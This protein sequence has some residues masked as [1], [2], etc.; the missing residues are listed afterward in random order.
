MLSVR[1]VAYT[2][3]LMHAKS[4]DKHH[5]DIYDDSRTV[6]TTTLVRP[7]LLRLQRLSRR[8]WDQPG[9]LKMKMQPATMLHAFAAVGIPSRKWRPMTF[10]Y[11]V[12]PAP[13][14]TALMSSLEA[15]ERAVSSACTW[16]KLHHWWMKWQDSLCF[17]LSWG[18]ILLPAAWKQKRWWFWQSDGGQFDDTLSMM[19]IVRSQVFNSFY[20]EDT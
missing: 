18:I 9:Q 5:H 12:A 16:I 13:W 3:L 6:K 7:M 19:Q 15:K 10:A 11:E 1:T 8:L 2:L 17:W 4:C 20:V 14:R